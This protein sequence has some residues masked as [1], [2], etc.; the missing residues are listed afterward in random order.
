MTETTKPTTLFWIIAVI[1]LLWNLSG[2]YA[3]FVEVFI[4]QEALAN[5]PDE[6]RALY[7]STPTWIKIVYGIA[8]ISGTAG[9]VY[10][11]L[12]RKIAYTLLVL[13]VTAALIQMVYSAAA[14]EAIQVFGVVAIIMPIIVIGFGVFLAWYSKACILKGWL[15]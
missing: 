2:L 14:T 4:S 11:L 13:S 7:Q 12:K 15:K 10:L 9:S 8:T 3:F 5:M 6:E 1:A